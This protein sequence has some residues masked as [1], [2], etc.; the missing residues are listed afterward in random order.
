MKLTQDQINRAMKTDPAQIGHHIEAGYVDG[1]I[2]PI[3][4]SF[5][6][7]GPAYTVRCPSNDNSV[8]YYAMSQA[9]AGSVLVVDRLGEHRIA[10]CGE[11]S[12]LNAKT[13]GLAGI[14]VDGVVTDSTQIKEIGLPV[15]ARGTASTACSLKYKDGEF[16]IPVHCGGVVVNPGDIVFGNAD[17]VIICPADEFET[18]L[19]QSEKDDQTEAEWKA[20]FAAGRHFDDLIPDLKEKVETRLGIKK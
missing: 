9:P 11:I 4:P 7:I 1:K 20:G 12:A 5:K 6:M 16:N 15:F 17:G 19:C 14:L 10:C 18:Y 2:K 8:I 13:Y 3:D